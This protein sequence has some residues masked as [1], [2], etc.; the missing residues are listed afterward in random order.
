MKAYVGDRQKANQFGKV[1]K[2]VSR[3]KRG[4]MSKRGK[5]EERNIKRENRKFLN[6]RPEERS[7]YESE[8][9]WEE[10]QITRILQAHY[11]NIVSRQAP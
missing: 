4:S 2:E 10:P 1:H 5:E 7:K 6:S 3:I 8:L 9:T 11:P